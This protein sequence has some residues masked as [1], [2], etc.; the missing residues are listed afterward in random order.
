[1]DWYWIWTGLGAAALF[2]GMVDKA[3][4]LADV[5]EITMKKEGDDKR[6]TKRERQSS[7]IYHHRPKQIYGRA[8]TMPSRMRVPDQAGSTVGCGSCEAHANIECNVVCSCRKGAFRLDPGRKML[9]WSD[10][11]RLWVEDARLEK[12]RRRGAT[13]L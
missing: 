9:R 2:S 10:L 11:R 5:T 13:P 1:M 6:Q 3:A 12:G 7:A 4:I 8:H